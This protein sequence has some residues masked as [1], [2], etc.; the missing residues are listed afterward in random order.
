MILRA[1]SHLSQLSHDLD[2]RQIVPRSRPRGPPR[3]STAV[4]ASSDD[5][6]INDGCYSSS[7]SFLRYGSAETS[8][9]T[10][11]RRF[12]RTQLRFAVRKTIRN[13]K[14]QC[15]QREHV[16]R[17]NDTWRLEIEGPPRD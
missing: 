3:I 10:N 15:Q 7:T 2:D 5:D 17:H 9:S 11:V 8:A 14:A 12:A 4:K 1:L 6:D 13:D 16:T